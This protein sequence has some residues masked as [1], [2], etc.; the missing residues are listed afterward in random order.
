MATVRPK[1]NVRGPHVLPPS[2]LFFWHTYIVLSLSINPTLSN[3]LSNFVQ[4]LRVATVSRDHSA[5]RESDEGMRGS[6]DRRHANARKSSLPGFEHLN[7]HHASITAL[8][9]KHNQTTTSQASAASTENREASKIQNIRNHFLGKEKWLG[10]QRGFQ[11]KHRS[12]IKR[13]IPSS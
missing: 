1:G 2:V 4:R 11:R 13:L 12:T 8:W 9:W 5:F 3:P 7:T 10:E 6:D